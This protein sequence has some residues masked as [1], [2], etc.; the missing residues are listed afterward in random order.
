MK[1]KYSD[2]SFMDT[3]F[4]CRALGNHKFGY[5]DLF[6]GKQGDVVGELLDKAMQDHE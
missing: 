5:S 1:K 2:G 6:E 3:C 4:N